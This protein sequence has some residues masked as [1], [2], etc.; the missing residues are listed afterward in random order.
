MP[1]AK[2]VKGSQRHSTAIKGRQNRPPTAVNEPELE[3]KL[4][5]TLYQLAR[6]ELERD[7]ARDAAR[8]AHDQLSK[9]HADHRA[10]WAQAARSAAIQERLEFAR[11]RRTI[12]YRSKLEWRLKQ[13][14]GMVMHI[15]N[16]MTMTPNSHRELRGTLEYLDV[17]DN[18][19]SSS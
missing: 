9:A 17:D 15:L 18:S 19:D 6:A 14:K 12:R 7:A 2:A 5:E 16:K 3:K 1:R 10:Q 8:D 4:Q 13:T 11:M